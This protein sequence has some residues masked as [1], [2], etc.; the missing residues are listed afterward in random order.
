VQSGRRSASTHANRV[1]TV[2]QPEVQAL[3]DEVEKLRALA[4]GQRQL[5]QLADDRLH[6]AL[7]SGGMG[8]WQFEIATGLVSWSPTL[9]QIH[10][11][12]IG[13]FGGTFEDYQRDIHPED[14]ERVLAT[15]SRSAAG[16]GEHHLAYRIV[17]PD[18]EIRW[19]EAWG[20]LFTN[21]AGQPMRMLGVCSD[22]TERMRAEAQRVQLLEQSEQAVR[23]RDDLLAMV[24]HDLR[25]P[26]NVISMASVILEGEIEGSERSKARVS[27][28]RRAARQMEELI[29]NLL[30][31]ASIENGRCTVVPAPHDL[32]ALLEE[33]LDNFVPVATSKGVRIERHWDDLVSDRPVLCD[34]ARMLQVLGNLLGNAL[35]FSA[36]GQAV[37][38]EARLLSE[39]VQVSV[40]DTGPG[41]AAEHL[42]LVFARYWKGKQSGRAGTGLGLF[43][44]KGIVDA[45]GGRIWVDSTLGQGSTFHFTLPLV[46]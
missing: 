31:A 43:I 13:S 19:L 17:R 46:R 38:I 39:M 42:D 36:S 35:R 30:D 6:L 37:A 41:I 25:D 34:R 5:A 32:T 3:R 45:H 8:A 4:H 44:S 14:R 7:A 24:S 23:A 29:S 2:S 1:D 15:I 21:D 12:P 33:A 26:L 9:E 20:R 10:G 18:G 28:I 16:L 27:M 40:R 11:L 22:V